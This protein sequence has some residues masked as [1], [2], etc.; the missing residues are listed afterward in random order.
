MNGLP[1]DFG[2]CWDAY[3]SNSWSRSFRL[4]EGQAGK[5]FTGWTNF[6]AAAKHGGSVVPLAVDESQKASGVFSLTAPS[7]A[8]FADFRGEREWEWDV[9]GESPEGVAEAIA[10]GVITWRQGVVA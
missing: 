6:R 9:K 4:R 10:C 1:Y 2:H 5:D 7:A 3:G 8:A